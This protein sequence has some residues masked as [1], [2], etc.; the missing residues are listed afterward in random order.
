MSLYFEYNYGGYESYYNTPSTD[1]PPSFFMG[2]LYEVGGQRISA[3][4]LS[5]LRY[6]YQS[7]FF[8]FNFNNELENDLAIV[9][10]ELTQFLVTP[11]MDAQIYA[12]TF[13]EAGPLSLGIHPLLPT[14][15]PALID[16]PVVVNEIV[17]A[18]NGTYNYS[19]C[20]IHIPFK[21]YLVT[22]IPAGTANLYTGNIIQSYFGT[23]SDL[24]H[25]YA[26]AYF[27]PVNINLINVPVA[28]PSY[29]LPTLPYNITA[30]M[31]M[32]GYVQILY[33]QGNKT[34]YNCAQ[35]NTLVE[36]S[37]SELYADGCKPFTARIYPFTGE[38]T[39]IKFIS[40][41]YYLFVHGAAGF[42]VDINQVIFKI[43]STTD[44]ITYTEII[45]NIRTKNIFEIIVD[46][47]TGLL[48]AIEKELYT[49]NVNAIYQ[50]SSDLTTWTSLH[51][52][53]YPI[54]I[55]LNYHK[56]QII[57]SVYYIATVYDNMNYSMASVNVSLIFIFK[58]TDLTTWTSV[59][60]SDSIYAFKLI[61]QFQYSS[62]EKI[63]S[64]Y[65]FL[66]K[67]AGD[68]RY[69]S[70]TPSEYGYNLQSND[71]GTTWVTKYISGNVSS[72]YVDSL[73]YHIESDAFYTVRL[74]M[75]TLYAGQYNFDIILTPYKI[76]Y[77]SGTGY[78]DTITSGTPVTKTIDMGRP[79]YTYGDE[80]GI[81]YAMRYNF[82]IQFNTID[83]EIIGIGINSNNMNL[84]GNKFF[85]IW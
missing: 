75:P 80:D 72:R 34:I 6:N 82:S 13:T 76:E 39:D 32:Y 49:R 27:I 57:N 43:Y 77:N 21:N 3:N 26:S 37:G 41:V 9:V 17:A 64:C 67:Q 24:E 22:D 18:N 25:L 54:R 16:S 11:G 62:W 70:I 36:A 15:Y 52:L 48:Y 45:T 28:I 23:R 4:N 63:G 56:L 29:T 73:G 69:Y 33:A 2:I 7:N 58:S 53:I 42:S 79:I 55:D 44:F 5:N 85:R 38:V 65:I 14:S 40:G 68:F 61:Q 19:C 84:H 78:F 12:T 47:E 60:T 81:F 35:S 51:D 46:H 71:G 8:Y 59:Y 31:Y 10:D 74:E 50:A 83:N 1:Y 20:D 66:L 30:F